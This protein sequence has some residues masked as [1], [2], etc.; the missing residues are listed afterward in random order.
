[1]VAQERRGRPR[2][3]DVQRK[4]AEDDRRTVFHFGFGDL[5]AV[6]EGPVPAA[7]ESVTTQWSP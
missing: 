3:L 5:I 4:A 6:Q 2:V 7:E 1:M